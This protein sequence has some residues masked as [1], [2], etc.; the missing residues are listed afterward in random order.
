MNI[1][2]YDLWQEK[3][4]SLVKKRT[5]LT[6][7][8]NVLVPEKSDFVQKWLPAAR[9]N[10]QYHFDCSLDEGQLSLNNPER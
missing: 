6:I 7:L 9:H 3:L 10:Q 8:A 1:I 2:A 4:L 5:D